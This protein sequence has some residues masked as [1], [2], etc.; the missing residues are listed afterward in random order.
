MIH[1]G[2]KRKIYNGFMA[3]I[4][5]LVLI[6]S[7]FERKAGELIWQNML[8]VQ[9]NQSELL[10]W[11]EVSLFTLFTVGQ[12]SSSLLLSQYFRCGAHFPCLSISID[13]HLKKTS[14]NSSWNVIIA[15]KGMTTQL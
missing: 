15:T 7:S 5:K 4:F 6:S 13:R 10:G 3:T 2:K 12:A 9:K 14:W 1:S 11:G 8:K